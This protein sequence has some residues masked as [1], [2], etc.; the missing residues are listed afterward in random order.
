MADNPQKGN[1]PNE[2]EPVIRDNRKVDPQTGKVRQP[3][4]AGSGD[5]GAGAAASA[6]E[7]VEAEGPDVETSLSDS[8]LGFLSGQMSAEELAAERDA[9]LK[10]VQAEFFNYRR[11]R[12]ASHVVERERTAGEVVKVLLP[13]LDD[14][15]RAEKHGDLVE[16]SPFTTIAAKLRGTVGK[17]GLVPFGEPGDV[18]DPNIHEALFQQPSTD[19]EVETIAEVIETGYHIGSSLLRAAKV[20]V[21]VPQD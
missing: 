19:V 12:E 4:S 15:D 10:R 13:I 5:A 2:D 18:F 8:D 1:E 9:E 3:D 11:A 21:A 17:L 7:F 14:L 16:G 6:P 20:V